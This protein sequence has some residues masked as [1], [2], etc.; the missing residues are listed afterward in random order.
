[1]RGINGSPHFGRRGEAGRIS[2]TEEEPG[3]LTPLR[4]P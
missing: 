3:S 4:A 1:M 2:M